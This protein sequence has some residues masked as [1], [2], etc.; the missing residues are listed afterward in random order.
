MS[1]SRIILSLFLVCAAISARAQNT[2]P[3]VS[4][5]IPAQALAPGG[6]PLSLDLTNYFTIQGVS[7]P[8]VQ[9][10]TVLGKFDV[11][12]RP[13][14]APNHVANFLS[15]VGN[16]RYSNSF[17]HR[18]SSFDG[19]AV[20]IVQGGGYY[21]ASDGIKPVPTDAPIGLEYNLPNAR[22]TLAA[23]RTSDVNSAT[24]QWYFNV[25]DNT[26]TLGPG[27][28]GGYTVFGRVLGSGM[29]VVDA[30]AALPRVAV[31]DG[32]TV[33]Y[34]ELPVRNYSGGNVSTSNLVVVN[35]ITPASFF[36]NSSAVSVATFSAQSSSSSVV[37]ASISGTTLVLTP[38]AG[39]TASV[40]V[41]ATDVNGNSVD[42]TFT[43]SV[44]AVLPSISVQPSSY[45]IA[46]GDTVVLNAAATA[47]SSYQWQRNGSDLP[48]ATDPRLVL[49]NVSANDAG[50]YRLIA[51]NSLGTTTS[52][53]ATLTVTNAAASD[54][55]RLINLSIRSNAG[56]G[57]ETLIVG[58]NVGGG[59]TS[60]SAPLLLR[61]AG[62]SLAQFG[63]SNFLPDPI[64]TLFSGQIAMASNNDW[65]GDA[66]VTARSKQVGAFDFSS[67]ASLDAALAVSPASGS[68]SMQI[69][70][71][72]G[73][74]GNALAEI[75]DATQSVT[76][77]SPRLTNVSAR[78]QVG[79]GD[80]VLIA[81]FVIRGSTAR[82]VL[83]RATGPALTDFGVSGILADPK[84][85]L[86]P[87]GTSTVIAEN[88]N[89]GGDAQIS[90]AGSRV[91]AF[92]LVNGGSKDA[93]LLVTLPPGNYSAQVTGADGG[94]GIGLIEVYEVR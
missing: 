57:T 19:G 56:T 51:R 35:S 66:T 79:T 31:G 14:V 3:G 7:G 73:T 45:T 52:N 4:R 34:P 62:P 25:R 10:D 49:T 29:S 8:V 65:E 47:A 33:V 37:N 32:Q 58:F 13:D 27:N 6:A 64:A 76:A 74:T 28:G 68:Y 55:G 30:I 54:I 26:S 70:G 39:G 88:D 61:A 46:V 80:N 16:G 41:R 63:V 48:G 5:T 84:L 40:T 71:N 67:A 77:S 81:G 94:T 92:P 89:W 9:Y 72:H 2:F 78:T 87:T 44:A 90:A 93:A 11:E 60:G 91:G 86:L 22:G 82:T 59:G 36:P 12:L 85:Q 15:Y 69:T 17:F 53:P 20:S 50:T 38:G 1:V 83:I 23:A 24:S 75:Y 21:I 18:S 43:V 42:N